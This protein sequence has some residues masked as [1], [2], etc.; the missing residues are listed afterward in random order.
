MSASMLTVDEV[1]AQ[2]GVS[3]SS[4]EEWVRTKSLASFKV[5]RLRKVSREELARWVLANTVRSRRPEWAT[6]EI[7]SE[8]LKLLRRLVDEVVE[9]RMKSL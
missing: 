3:K 5:G 6:A 9:T 4:V 7:E 1:A 2:L 8:F